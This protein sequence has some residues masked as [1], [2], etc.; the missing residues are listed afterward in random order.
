MR[1]VSVYSG[2]GVAT[3]I[4]EGKPTGKPSYM[5]NTHKIDKSNKANNIYYTGLRQ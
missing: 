3:Q 2:L 4:G 1:P 5:T